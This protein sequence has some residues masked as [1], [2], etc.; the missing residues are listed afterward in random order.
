[1]KPTTITTSTITQRWISEDEAAILAHII[2]IDGED[3]VILSREDARNG[4]GRIVGEH[5]TITDEAWQAVRDALVY[6]GDIKALM[7]E[8]A[9][10]GDLGMVDQCAAAL[11]GDIDARDAC[12][13][14][15][16]NARAAH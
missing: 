2:D 11:A 3:A 8:A 16:L 10:A 4:S 5:L 13:A 14:T 7:Q 12:A 15:I 6:D 9:Q 1:M